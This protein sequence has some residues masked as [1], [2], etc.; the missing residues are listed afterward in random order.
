MRITTATLALGDISRSSKR[1][2]FPTYIAPRL[3]IVPTAILVLR[4][5]CSDQTMMI[6]SPPRAKS[7]NIVTALYV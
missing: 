3:R 7:Q 6:G 5:I 4:S 2:Q 1:Y